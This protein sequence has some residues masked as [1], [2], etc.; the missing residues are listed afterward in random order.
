M[1]KPFRDNSSGVGLD[2]AVGLPAPVVEEIGKAARERGETVAGP[3]PGCGRVAGDRSAGR[4]PNR[5]HCRGDG[6]RLGAIPDLGGGRRVG[7]AVPGFA[8]LRAPPPHR[9][10][11]GPSGQR[12]RGRQEPRAPG[13]RG[14]GASLRIGGAALSGWTRS[15][16]SR[17]PSRPAG[18]VLVTG[19]WGV[20]YYALSG[21]AMFTTLDRYLFLP[22]DHLFG[23]DP[24][25]LH[26]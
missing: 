3:A 20:N 9:P 2:M 1:S 18:C 5:I 4:A 8:R 16:R 13:P 7:P 6:W 23:I 19:V 22:P 15:P 24:C 10:T 17:A 14:R 11:R 26:S 12:L 25:K 21:S